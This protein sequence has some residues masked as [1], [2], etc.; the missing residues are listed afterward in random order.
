[1]M[2]EKRAYGDSYYVP[3]RLGLGAWRT[4]HKRFND[5]GEETHSTQT[6][7]KV[8]EVGI[9]PSNFLSDITSNVTQAPLSADFGTV[10]SVKSSDTQSEILKPMDRDTKMAYLEGIMKMKD[11]ALMDL[12]KKIEPLEDKRLEL[13][14]LPET[15]RNGPLLK[16]I[17]EA[18]SDMRKRE[19][20]LVA[21]IAK[22]EAELSALK[23]R[24]EPTHAPV[25]AQ[26]N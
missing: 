11:F 17:E 7:T 21:E 1:M 20:W 18:L 8:M 19:A 15:H 22:H 3:H 2:S 25:P 24:K 10:A 14:N 16:G 26:G 9:N 6:T 23:N 12:L 5:D 13:L 4:D